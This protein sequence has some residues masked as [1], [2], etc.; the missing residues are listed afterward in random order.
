M[1]QASPRRRA[2]HPLSVDWPALAAQRKARP[3]LEALTAWRNGEATADQQRL[4]W[5]AVQH[6]FCAVNGLSWHGDAEG[7]QRL[8]D[9]LEGRRSVAL[10]LRRATENSLQHLTEGPDGSEGDS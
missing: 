5:D 9:A 7:G 2:V 3:V 8:T 1:R 6:V 4:A 10:Q